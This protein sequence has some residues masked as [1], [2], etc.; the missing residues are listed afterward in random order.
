MVALASV[1]L[2]KTASFDDMTHIIMEQMTGSRRLAKFLVVRR[3]ETELVNQ[4]ST[5]PRDEEDKDELD[6]RQAMRAVAL[7]RLGR[8]EKV[9][10]MLRHSDDPSVRSYIVNWLKPLGA[11]P[12]TLITKLESLPHDPVPIPK[13]GKSR[14]DAVLYHP[15]TSERRALIL[16][17]GGYEAY[18]LS[19]TEREPVM[20]QLLEAYR[21]DPDAGVHG[22][23]EWTLRRW[24]QEETLKK[25]DAELQRLKDRGNRRWYV[26]SEGQTL[27]VI[28]G[29]VEF[30]MGSPLSEPD[31]EGD[32]TQHR[33]PI[34]RRFAIATKEVTVK[35]YQ[36]FLK[37]NPKIAR[38]ENKRN[39]PEPTGPMNRMSWYEAAAYCNWLSEQE[40]L[41]PCYE[42]I[43]EGEYAEGMKILPDALKLPGYRLPTEAEWEY[44]CRAGAVT[45]RYY[46]RS[47]ELLG[48]YAW[49]SKNSQDRAWPCG[50]LLPNELGLFDM[51]GNVY[52]WCQEQYYR[53]PEGEGNTTTDDIKILVTIK[54][55]DVR[56]LR[57]G[58]FLD[59]PASVRSAFRSGLY[60]ALRYGNYG[61][62]P[63]RTWRQDV[64]P[65]P[66]E[67]ESGLISR[68]V[69]PSPGRRPVPGD[70]GRSDE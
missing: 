24:K 22:A 63:S 3:L 16:A 5:E 2:V 37:E 1:E 46:G 21:T 52:E 13:D 60:P 25:V 15:D 58:S 42:P 53:Y 59:G 17:L 61:F 34:N 49:Y 18:D 51:L 33:Q 12:K 8:P 10:P 6:Q 55:Q 47:V 54:E 66:P 7:A 41:K 56:L 44:A 36:Q 9:W 39:S 32:E 57:G 4:Q 23:A 28:E 35:Q 27:A 50:Q 29:P 48:K 40:H 62:R 38:L 69:Q 19:P 70:L 65:V 45:S 43:S 67:F 11:D 26:N 31:R 30:S 14:M 20:A 68:S 64:H